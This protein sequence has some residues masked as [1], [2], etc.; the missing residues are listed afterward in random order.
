MALMIANAEEN[1]RWPDK[2]SAAFAVACS[3]SVL[4]IEGP[5]PKRLLYLLQ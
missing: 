2:T 4:G 1:W 5:T 3:M